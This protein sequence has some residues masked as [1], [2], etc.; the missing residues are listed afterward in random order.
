MKCEQCQFMYHID[1][2]HTKPDTMFCSKAGAVNQYC[3]TVNPND[4]CKKYR[5][6]KNPNI[7]KYNKGL[8]SVRTLKPDADVYGL[9]NAKNEYLKMSKKR[10]KQLDTQIKRFGF[11]DCETGDLAYTSY[12]WLYSHIKMMLDLGGKLVDFEWAWWD[13]S[14]KQKLQSVGVDINKYTNDKMV[15]EYICELIEEA[16]RLNYDSILLE[17]EI[18][19]YDLLQKAFTIYGVMLPRA[20][21]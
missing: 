1:N 9:P 10:H 11:T 16:D 20:W 18:K 19:A 17:D 21:W 7:N 15:F 6:A 12:V 14:F 2:K 5:K 13:D 8:K 3:T 4:N